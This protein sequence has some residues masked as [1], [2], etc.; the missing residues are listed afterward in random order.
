MIRR[1][2]RSTLDRSSA[3]SDV[4]K[5]QPRF[6]PIL[7]ATRFDE[8][9]HILLQWRETVADTRQRDERGVRRRAF[10]ELQRRDRRLHER[11]GEHRVQHGCPAKALDSFGE[12]VLLGQLPPLAVLHERFER[13]W[14]RR[15]DGEEPVSYT[16]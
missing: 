9:D 16:H 8:C 12:F 7:G 5:R 1:P 10:A 11:P 15:R 3:A 2:P 13:R 14:S 4:Y 6:G